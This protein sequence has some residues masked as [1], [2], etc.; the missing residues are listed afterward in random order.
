[1]AFETTK[2]TA[3]HVRIGNKEQFLISENRSD[4]V[5]K[6][7]SRVCLRRKGTY[8]QLLGYWRGKE[9]YTPGDKTYPRG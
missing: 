1:L 9:R 5:I 2:V 6:C 4:I 7:C 8:N 3:L